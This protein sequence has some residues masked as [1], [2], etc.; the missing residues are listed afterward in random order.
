MTF[1]GFRANLK[2]LKNENTR[3]KRVH[4]LELYRE[5]LIERLREKKEKEVEDDFGVAGLNG[6]ETRIR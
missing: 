4:P 5:L 3:K 2:K 6:Y 1:R